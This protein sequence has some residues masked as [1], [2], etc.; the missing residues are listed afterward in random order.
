MD[1]LSDRRG[2]TISAASIATVATAIID[3][4]RTVFWLVKS[5]AFPARK[6]TAAPAS[7]IRILLISRKR[8][9][10][11]LKVERIPRDSPPVTT[12]LNWLIMDC[13]IEMVSARPI[14]VA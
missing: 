10:C 1:Y 4:I 8:G 12:P 6:D 3:V 14:G 9:G 5:I 11:V 2:R 7:M 13:I